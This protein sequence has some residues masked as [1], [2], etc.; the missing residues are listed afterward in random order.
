MMGRD[1]P[2]KEWDGHWSEPRRLP[3]VDFP[4]DRRNLP[5]RMLALTRLGVVYRT[6]VAILARL[7][8]ARF[9]LGVKTALRQTVS[10]DS[11]STTTSRAARGPASSAWRAEARAAHSTGATRG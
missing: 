11:S 3:A 10:P 4:T 6:L 8:V 1:D 9:A 5:G 7:W 2:K